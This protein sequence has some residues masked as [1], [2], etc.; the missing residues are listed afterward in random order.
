MRWTLAAPDAR[1]VNERPDPQQLSTPR[2]LLLHL[3]PGALATALFVLLADPVQRAGF[4]PL[5]AFLIAIMV[6]IVPAELGIVVVAGRRHPE[7]PGV[8]AAVPYRRP[9]SLREWIILL[10]GLLIVAVIGFGALSFVEPGIRD[11]LFGWV[12]SWSRELIDVDAVGDY[13]TAAWTLTL[14]LYVVLNVFIG[15]VV[16][17]L[18]FR[19]YL[20]PR[21]SRMGRWAPIANTVLFSLYHFWSPWGF[22]SRIAGVAPFAYAV[23]RKENVYLGMAVHVL[24]NAIGT[25]SLVLLIL[26]KLG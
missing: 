5:L 11:A 1:R 3:A 8:L 23:W 17:E 22:F 21:M 24:L 6:V 18:Y 2:L 14:A 9:M 25:S 12:P 16:E 19:G 7:T 10:P 13:S 26:G 4:P 15:P 20:L